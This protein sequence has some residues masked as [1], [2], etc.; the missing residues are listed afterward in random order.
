MTT[1]NII[2]V[3]IESILLIIFLISSIWFKKWLALLITC[4]F[5]TLIV[6]L[7]ILHY[8]NISLAFFVLLIIYWII[9]GRRSTSFIESDINYEYFNELNQILNLEPNVNPINHNYNNLLNNAPIN[10]YIINTKKALSIIDSLPRPFQDETEA[11][12][13]LYTTL[14][15]LVGNTN[16][17]IYEPKE[18]GSTIGDI[19]IDNILIEGK[20]DLSS[21]TETDR[22][23]GQVQRYCSDT[24]YNVFIVLYG[25]VDNTIYARLSSHFLK[26]YSD[27]VT[28][29][30]I[31]NPQRLRGN[32]ING[33]N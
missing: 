13:Q 18:N 8:G 3:S 4:L 2:Q 30:T 25:I 20:L 28:I 15:A 21:I 6:S 7:Q 9:W 26:Y 11:N 23:I 5:I 10:Y 32:R 24:P 27:K 22:L 1:I 14:Q 29:L 33:R 17:I 19:Q 31:D 16:T 12:R